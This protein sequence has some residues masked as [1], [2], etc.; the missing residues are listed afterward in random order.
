[1]RLFKCVL[2]II[3]LSTV[4]IGVFLLTVQEAGLIGALNGWGAAI[5]AAVIIVGAVFLIFD[6]STS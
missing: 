2:G 3:I 5:G 6:E 1:M 4:V